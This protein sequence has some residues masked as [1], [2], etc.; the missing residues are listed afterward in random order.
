MGTFFKYAIIRENLFKI[1]YKECE[2]GEL[3]INP[4]RISLDVYF[5]HKPYLLN[6]L[7]KKDRFLN[8]V[9]VAL[10]T[11][12]DLDILEKKIIKKIKKKCNGYFEKFEENKAYF[13][14]VYQATS[15]IGEYEKY[16]NIRK[17]ENSNN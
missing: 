14:P 17:T 15:I 1:F 16:D 10:I 3:K 4:K 2:V 13:I 8:D 11:G 12:Q 6:C 5:M 7:E 9:E